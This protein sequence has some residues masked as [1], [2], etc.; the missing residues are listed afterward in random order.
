MASFR[1]LARIAVMQ[2]IFATEFKDQDAEV[3]LRS[4]LEEFAGKVTEPEFAENL[5]AKILAEKAEIFKII[6][7][8]APNWPI[9]K[10]AHIDRAVLEIGIAEIVYFS[11]DV[12]P[13]VAINEAIE[14][15]KHYG[16]EN[17]PKFINGVLSSV[18]ESYK[19]PPKDS[20]SPKKS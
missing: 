7:K 13:V 20:E 5:L 11:D 14:I 18:M 10:I 15:A 12:P 3:F 19:Q 2:T 9:D 8:F 4:V 6:E 16:D 1:H 17:S